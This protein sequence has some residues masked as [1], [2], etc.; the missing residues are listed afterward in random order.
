[1]NALTRRWE[2]LGGGADVQVEVAFSVVCICTKMTGFHVS[3]FSSHSFMFPVA[4]GLGPP[5]GM[6]Q[7][8]EHKVLHFV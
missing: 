7:H 4:G 3:L 8:F 5:Q 1:M 6:Y 2:A